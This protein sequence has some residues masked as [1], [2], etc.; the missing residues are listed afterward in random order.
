MVQNQRVANGDITT[1]TATITHSPPSYD[2]GVG[3]DDD[4]R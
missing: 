1:T 3:D 2:D 4:H